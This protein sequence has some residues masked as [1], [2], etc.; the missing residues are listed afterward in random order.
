MFEA[1]L[2]TL[3]SV[4][5]LGLCVLAY[6]VQYARIVRGGYVRGFGAE[7]VTRVVCKHQRGGVVSKTMR[8]DAC[9]HRESDGV[10]LIWNSYVTLIVN[11]AFEAVG[12]LQ[13]CWYFVEDGINPRACVF[14]LTLGF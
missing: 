2:D 4:L 14:A 8:R 5:R 9:I 6:F 1:G 3:L 11:C 13:T 12:I 10:A 7:G